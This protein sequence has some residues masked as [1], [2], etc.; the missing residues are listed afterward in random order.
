MIYPRE[1]VF[2]K[3]GGF[4]GGTEKGWSRRGKRKGV[5]Q[6]EVPG[7]SKRWWW[8]STPRFRFGGLQGTGWEPSGCRAG[9]LPRYEKEKGV[10]KN[11][12]GG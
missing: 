6:E 12:T 5:R 8:E 2:H 3:K 1:E 4:R 9:L 10:Q 11:D 7:G